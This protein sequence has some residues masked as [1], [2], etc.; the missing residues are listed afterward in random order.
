MRID[1]FLFPSNVLYSFHKYF[2]IVY[3]AQSTV[4]VTAEEAKGEKA[5]R[6]FPQDGHGQSVWESV[7]GP[8]LEKNAE[9][10]R[11]EKVRR[12][13]KLRIKACLTFKFDN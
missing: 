12:G 10:G 4:L 11:V 3:H 7:A 6:A 9:C 8:P 5:S 2:L 1:C 13:T